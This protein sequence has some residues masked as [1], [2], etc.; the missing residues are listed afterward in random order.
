[1][2]L[3]PLRNPFSNAKVVGDGIDGQAYRKQVEGVGR[4]DKA[5]V[6]SRSE[7]M[8]FAS[9]PQ[10]W[11]DG[12]QPEDTNATDWGSLIDTL[13]TDRRR[14][15]S[16]YILTPETC[17]ATK[18]MKI[19]KN[20]DARE[21]DPVPWSP[22]ASEC[23]EWKADQEAKGLIVLSRDK[24][25][26][27]NAAM[28]RLG[29]DTV[30]APYLAVSRF[31]LMAVADYVDAETKIVVPV[32]TLIDLAPRPGG[33][34]SDSLG[35]FKTCR[36]AEPENWRKVV[37][38]RNYDVQA[39]M[40]LAIYNKATGEGRSTWYHVLQ[41]NLYPWQTGRR[42]VS[43]MFQTVGQVKALD[44]LRR[45]SRCLATDTWPSWDDEGD[46][47]YAGWGDCSPKEWTIARYIGQV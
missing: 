3:P 5:F 44:A 33:P 47:N 17:T 16:R 12:Y 19:V 22:T 39:W 34:F 24:W 18:T 37:D 28:E 35:D 2:E 36:S 11:R 6:M 30:I 23:K 13:V 31:Q 15:D 21:G 42:L 45:Y 26:E 25:G 40:S 27:A 38:D 1:M 4:G 20:G 8:L 9:N 32:K 10:R 46:R 41:E 29:K 14:F 43:S 7:L